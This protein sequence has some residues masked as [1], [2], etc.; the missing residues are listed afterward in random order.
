MAKVLISEQYLE[1]IADSIR[2]KLNSEETYTPAEMSDAIDTFAEDATASANDILSGKTAYT[3]AGKITGN[4]S[5]KS[6]SDLS[7]SGATVTVPAGYY[8]TT[9]TATVDSGSAT[10]PNTT[11]TTNPTITVSNTGLITASYSGSKSVTPNIT[12]GYVTEGIAGTVS[13][14][15]SSTEQ[16]TTQGATTYNVSTSDQEIAAGTYLVGKQTIKAV[17][18]AGIEANNIKAGT[19]VKVGDTSD[20]DSIAGVTGTFTSASTVSTGQTA[21]SASD[22]RTGASAWVNGAEVQGSLGNTSVTEGTTTISQGE[23]SRGNVT[24][25]NGVIT[26]GSI[27]AATFS[28][29]SSA[30]TSYVDISDTTEAP[31]LVSNDYLYINRGYTDNLKISLAKLVPDG[32]SAGLASNKI[33]SGYSAY[34]NDGV[35]VAGNIQ[36]QAGGT[37]YSTTAD[38]TILSGGKFLTSNVTIGKTTTSNLNAANIKY[39]TTVKVGDEDDDDRIA[40]ITGTFTRANT[41]SAGQIAASTDKIISGYSAWVNGAEVKGTIPERDVDY[42]TID[43]SYVSV[44]A[45]Y[46]AEDIE[47]EVEPGSIEVEATGSANINSL[48]YTY[49]S[50]SGNFKVSGHTN[51]EGDAIAYVEPGY[52]LSGAMGTIDGTA[53]VSATVAKIAGTASISGNT[54]KKPTIARTTTTAAGAINVGTGTASTTPP[55]SGYFVAV[56]S[57]AETETISVTP[58]ITAAGYGTANYHGIAGSTATA[59]ALASDE[60]YIT[61]PSGSVSVSNTAITANPTISINSAGKITASYNSSN[62]ITPV[63]SAGY[64]TSGTAGTV[65]VSGSAE[66]QLTTKGATTYNV[67]TSDQTIATGTYLIGT[68]TIKGVSTTGIN[69]ANIRSGI[70]VK[71][72]DSGDDDRIAGVTG[73]FTSASTVSDGQTAATA[74]QIL[75]GY[76]AWVDGVEV[77]GDIAAKTSA[78]MTVSGKTVTAPAGFY[79]TAQSKSVADGS[80]SVAGAGTASITGLTYNYNS[81]GNNFTV[82]G[83][84]NITGSATATVTAGYIASGANAAL[85]GTANVSTSVAKVAGSTTIS[86]S[87]LKKPSIVRTTTTAAG[88]TNVGFGDA[89]TTKP[90]SGYFVAVKSNENTGT[91]TATPSITTAGYGTSA[92]HALTGATATVGA[93]ASDETYIVVPSGSAS[94]PATTITKNPTISVDASGLITASYSGSQSITPTVN[95]GYVTAGTAGT[96]S[97]SGSSTQQLTT[98]DAT[99]YN[100]SSS[101]QEIVAGTYLTGKQTIKAVTT[102]NISAANIKSGVT[103]KVGDANDDDRIAGVAGTFTSASTVSSGQTAAAAGQIRSGYSAW[104]DGVEV[105]G[106]LGNTSV[107]QGNTTVSGTTATRGTASWGNGVITS[108]SIAAATFANSATSGTTYVDISNTTDAPILISG[109]ALYINKG[110]V[111]NLKISLAK[112]VPDGASAGLASGHILSGY[113]AYNNDGTLIAGNIASK[114]SANVTHSGK[115]VTVPAGYYG[116]EVTH[117]IDTGTVVA[118]VSSNTSGSASVAATGFTASGTA[119]DYYVTLSTSAGSV[120]AKATGGTAGYITSSTTNETTA[121][122]VAVSGNGTKL[123]IPTAG[124][125]A[126]V[127]SNTS[128]SASMSATG[129]TA[130]TGSTTSNYYVTLSTSAGSVKAKAIG[131]GTGIV[132]SSTSNETGATSVAVSGNETKLYIPE[133]GVS[134]SVSSNTSGSA[135][136]AATGFTASGTAT[137]YYITLSTSAGSVKA[138]AVGTGTGIITNTTSNET[139][140][141][142]VAVSGNGTKLYI[143]TAGV[144][145]SVSSNTSGS[146]SMGATGFTAS[147]TATDYYVMLSTSAGSVKAKAVGTGTGIV[148]S[149]TQNETAATNV[150]VSGNG[151]KLYIPAGSASTPATTITATPTISVNASG[152]I[153]ASVSAS[154]SVTPTVTSG[155]VASGS[156][157]TVSASGS[158]TQQLTVKAATTYTPTTAN[159]TIAAGTYLTGAQT[160]A[161]DANLVAGNIVSGVT[162][163]YSIPAAAGHSF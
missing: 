49:N 5:S 80:V 141:T 101:D 155:Y 57:N 28:N 39:G 103:V 53:S 87:G 77:Q 116:S 59:G 109:D 113:S 12:A 159:Q 51:I 95:S 43:G 114:T 94:T 158:A 67:S 58:T 100:I 127:S 33:L 122:S 66:Q 144:S 120:K 162:G 75:S 93:S 136:V 61:V 37:F 91:I 72:G 148:T 163:T 38:N 81:S 86:G 47:S 36:S 152:L 135:S 41:V 130:L 8:S 106:S 17:T 129:F 19:T 150:A 153:T 14:N 65:S 16:L 62:Q 89:T 23:V 29:S 98:K 26:S 92:N 70:T 44:P 111:D 151:N 131:T 35:L 125:S 48:T 21:A 149:S 55:G 76:S 108:G 105:K 52:I 133:A 54:A 73:L 140:A 20:D 60:T 78:D 42:I 161:G 7:S 134:A 45:G 18:T 79:A 110:Y 63:V 112:L 123:Y 142:S 160:I 147:S 2:N 56:K 25:D 96:V 30:G 146:A 24:W 22:I 31:V 115:T 137:D 88:A 85:T 4:V 157:G 99:T 143:P 46:Y 132:T 145:A 128:G 97:T 118:S 3:G 40:N 124:V 69:A 32:A 13:V 84:A 50:S 117:D 138:K 74:G 154:K 90:S 119:T 83:S 121:T 104:V 156:A 1:D 9:A 27:D 71:V 102:S 64:V 6:S 107:S 82:S 139:A 11:I 10:T 15:G 68:Q 34:N 126:S